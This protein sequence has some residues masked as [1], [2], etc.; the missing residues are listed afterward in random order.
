M[1]EDVY[2]FWVGGCVQ[3]DT[4]ASN[5]EKSFCVKLKAATR[6]QMVPSIPAG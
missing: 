3:I 5:V 2:I 6:E 1:P 4:I